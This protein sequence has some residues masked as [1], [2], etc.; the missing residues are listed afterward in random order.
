MKNPKWYS[1]GSKYYKSVINALKKSGFKLADDEMAEIY[2]KFAFADGYPY[3]HDDLPASIRSTEKN[4]YGFYSYS[5]HERSGGILGAIMYLSEL[6]E[7]QEAWLMP[8]RDDGEY[9]SFCF[10]IAVGTREE[11]LE[12]LKKL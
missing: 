3:W 4:K 7:G 8:V 12:T 11:V 2:S 1:N 5:N 6:H 9:V 10:D